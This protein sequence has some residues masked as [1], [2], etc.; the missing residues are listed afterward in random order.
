[1]AVLGVVGR[2][3]T[4]G[5]VVSLVSDAQGYCSLLTSGRVD[6]WGAGFKG[7]L[8]DGVFLG[9]AVPVTVVGVGGT[10][11][12]SR[13]ASLAS[14]QVGTCSVLTSGVVDCW[15]FG[16]FGQLGDGVFYDAGGNFGSAVPVAVIT[17]VVS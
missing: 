17:A 12:L 9:R 10:G 13:V 15:G 4:L 7:E 16:A 8:G 14:D 3:G 2:S 11:S 1:V 6:C 5:G